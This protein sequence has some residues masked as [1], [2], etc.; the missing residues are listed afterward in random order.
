MFV[1]ARDAKYTPSSVDPPVP[2]QNTLNGLLSTLSF[3]GDRPNET[4]I[5]PVQT[6]N[7]F[8]IIEA[9]KL[10]AGLTG[11]LMCLCL[12]LIA[13]TSTKYMRRSFYNL[14]WYSHQSIG[15]LF[16][17]LFC[18]HGIQG[19]IRKQTN[20][21]GNDPQKCYL[22]YSK[23][24]KRTSRVCDIPQFGGSMATSWIWLLI[25]LLVYIAERF[26]RLV[27]GHLIKH[28]LV[29]FIVHPSSV[30]ELR[31]DNQSRNR[32]TYRA[33]QY[34]YLNSA[35]ISRLEWHPFTITTSPS[36]PFLSVHVRCAGDWTSELKK[37]LEQST[38]NDLPNDLFNIDG[39]YGSCAEDIFRY[40]EVVLVG[41]GIGV[42]PYA[43]ILKDIW[44][45]L[46]GE[47]TN[48]SPSLLKLKKVHF[49]SICSTIDSF[50]WFGLLLQDL[51]TKTQ[52]S[53][54]ND[55]AARFLD[56]NVYL[57][58]GWSLREAKK[59]ADNANDAHDLFTGLRQKTNY[60]RPNFDLFFRNLVASHAEGKTE[61][62]VFFC[63]PSQLSKELHLLCNK[64]S[65]E[66]V[67]FIY[68]KENF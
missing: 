10:A 30:L 25:S 22:I 38:A 67:K 33:G 31:F 39:P 65:S 40:E 46:G 35:K 47:A 56:L 51:E 29:K 1:R 50:E 43:S 54:G 9:F 16:L 24:A 42:T 2:D 37:H 15:A 18:V 8:P 64:H 44:H 49:F 6:D 57:T 60:G 58:R 68:N 17:V 53:A 28:D 48:G 36:D 11:L 45:K 34:V 13:S 3:L 7:A 55:A 59:I 52:A 62:G 21:A 23:W 5:N 27:R 20:L 4:Y 66:R 26:I 14:F 61:T 32:I 41:A 63:G 12:S 19:V